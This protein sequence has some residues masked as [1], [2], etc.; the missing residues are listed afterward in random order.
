MQGW[1]N[2]CVCFT[3]IARQLDRLWRHKGF[4]L[5]NILDDFLFSVSGTFE[6]CCAVR[7]EVLRDMQL[8]GFYVSWAKSVLMPSRICKFM[9]VLVDSESMRFHMPGEKIENLESLIKEF[10]EG[11]LRVT[12]RRMAWVVGT[13]MS[14]ATAVSCAR[15]FTRETYKCI[16]PDD[17]WDDLGV[18][19]EDMIEELREALKWVRIFNVHGAPIRK[20][21]KQGGLRLMLDAS[22]G[23]YGYRLD[24]EC[25]DVV[26]RNSSYMVAA[27]WSGDVWEDQAHRE[28]AALVDILEGDDAEQLVGGK[29]LLTWTDS[30]ATRAYNNKGSGSSRVMTG[31]MKRVF[32]CCIRLGCSLWAEHVKGELLVEAGVDACSR[33]TEFKLATEQFRQITASEHFGRRGGFYGFTVDALASVKTKQLPVYMSRG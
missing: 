15:L 16:R 1:V 32:A 26:W 23:G 22:K 33:A 10:L 20:P 13:I 31:L 28:L 3:K 18:I 7:D 9:G 19:S 8:L 25:R 17:D 24:G 11:P 2:S 29:R 30:I 4:R 14:I 27:Q 21:A 6:E 12:F 5:A